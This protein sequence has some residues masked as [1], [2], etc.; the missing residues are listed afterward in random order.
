MLPANTSSMQRIEQQTS[1]A[2]VLKIQ[3]GLNDLA[4]KASFLNDATAC[5]SQAKPLLVFSICTHGPYH[6]LWASV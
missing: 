3:C 4:G 5:G 1:G 2:C 6:E